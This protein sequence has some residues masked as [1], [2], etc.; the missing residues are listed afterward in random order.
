MTSFKFGSL[1]PDGTDAEHRYPDHYEWERTTGPVRLVVAP[2]GSHVDLL[3]ALTGCWRGPFWIL[4]V[5]SVPRTG[6]LPGRYQSPEPL[7]QADVATFLSTHR[8]FLEGDARHALWVASASAEGTLVYDRH[9]VLYAYG[10]IEMFEAVLQAHGIRR[11][12]VELPVPHSHH[13]HDSHDVAETKLLG[14]LDWIYSPL[15][16][17]DED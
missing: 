7:G 1:Q 12:P 16:E 4:Y 5:L 3:I 9:N 13:Y 8:S 10:P 14:A 17:G 15:Q 2:K 6:A 11:G